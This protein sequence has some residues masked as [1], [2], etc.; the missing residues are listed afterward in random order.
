MTHRTLYYQYGIKV[1]LEIRSES[2]FA[3]QNGPTL[4]MI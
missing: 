4:H 3:K 1:N 2:V